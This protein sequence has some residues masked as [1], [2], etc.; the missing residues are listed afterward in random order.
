M[1]TPQIHLQLMFVLLSVALAG[2]TH[3]EGARIVLEKPAADGGDAGNDWER[4]LKVVE[5]TAKSAM[6]T[7]IADKNNQVCREWST[8]LD[9]REGIIV[10]ACPE[11]EF[12]GFHL[13]TSATIFWKAGWLN[14]VANSSAKRLKRDLIA[15]VRAEFGDRVK[16]EQ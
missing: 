13:S 9:A 2:C 1:R 6:L 15:A 4:F 11:H 10:N 5:T 14:P 8:G 12:R 3:H 16:A 7:P